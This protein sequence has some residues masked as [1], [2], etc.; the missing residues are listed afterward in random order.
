MS[1][2]TSSKTKRTDTPS[3]ALDRVEIAI[4]PAIERHSTVSTMDDDASTIISTSE[5]KPEIIGHS[6]KVSLVG[7]LQARC[8]LS[9]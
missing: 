7:R 4:H 8:Q 6:S 9:L 3:N 1:N 2:L 5:Q